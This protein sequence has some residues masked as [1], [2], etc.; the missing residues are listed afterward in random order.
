MY[1]HKTS[2][3]RPLD[4]NMVLSR[5]QP[6]FSLRPKVS[7]TRDEQ[8]TSPDDYYPAHTSF[9]RCHGR[10]LGC[11]PVATE[12][13]RRRE[14][15]DFNEIDFNERRDYCRE[16]T[17]L[18]SNNLRRKNRP[19]GVSLPILSLRRSQTSIGTHYAPSLCSAQ[20]SYQPILFNRQLA[21]T[22]I[23]GADF[24]REEMPRGNLR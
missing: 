1:T 20:P 5:Y 6:P 22:L 3:D 19:L 8:Q 21:C 14:K 2:T 11:A 23:T 4:E 9:S 16:M 15:I 24:R 10:N 13:P 18:G 17:Q 12:E 7:E